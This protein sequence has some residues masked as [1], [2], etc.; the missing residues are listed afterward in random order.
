MEQVL[1]TDAHTLDYSIR[2]HRG[3]T[4]LHHLA[5]SSMTPQ[6]TFQRVSVRSGRLKSTVDWEQ[7]SVLHLA[8]Q[9]G[10]VAV[11]EYVIAHLDLNINTKDKNGRTPLHHAVESSRAAK[12]IELLISNGADMN[13]RDNKGMSALNIAVRRDKETA[14]Q[15]LMDAEPSREILMDES[16]VHAPIEITEKKQTQ[17]V[18]QVLRHAV[19]LHHNHLRLHFTKATVKAEIYLK[20]S[21]FGRGKNTSAISSKIVYGMLSSHFLSAAVKL[22]GGNLIMISFV[23]LVCK[24]WSAYH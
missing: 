3:K 14:I 4:L 8:V 1:L 15:A 10:N 5:W 22:L 24:T 13:A 11:V 21:L 16:C 7:R 20:D 6:E 19:E 12:T 2:D 9:R 18:L 17:S 23:I